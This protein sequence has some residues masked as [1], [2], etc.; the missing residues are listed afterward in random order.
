MRGALVAILTFF[1]FWS[2][3]API[4][5]GDVRFEGNKSYSGAQL[6]AILRNRYFVSLD[7]DFGATDVNDA[8]FY[9]RTFYLTRGY[10]NADVAS[11]YRPTRPP[12]ALFVINEGD[13]AQIG[14]VT[15][16]GESVLG[17]DE[18][19]AV[20]NAAVRQATLM[21][22]G[23]MRYVESAVE[24][25]RLAVVNAMVLRGCLLANATV[26]TS[27]GSRDNFVNVT[28]HL[29]PGVQ[30][31]VRD[32]TFSG[33]PQDAATLRGVLAD[34]IN[35]PFQRNQ[36]TLMRN[37]LLDWLRNHGYLQAEVRSDFSL[38]AAT[39][40]VVG[41]FSIDAGRVYTI[42]RIRVEGLK[43]TRERAVR[44][45]VAL[46][47]GTTYDASR[48]DEAARRLWF[49]GAF[50]EADIEREPQPDGT[51]DL[52][53]KVAESPA[54]RIQFGL[55]YSQWEQVYGEIHYVDRNLFGT[56][57]RFTIDAGIS[58][59]TY[60]IAAGLADPWIFG[61]DLEGSAQVSLTRRELPAYRA[62]QAAAT[63]SLTRRFNADT[64]TGY[65]FQYGY[66]LVTDAVVFGDDSDVPD[67]NY[68]VGSIAFGQTWDTRNN[69]LSPMKG[70]YLNY[71][72]QLANPA[73]LGSLSFARV[74]GQ[75]TYYQPLRPITTER[76]FV[77]F[78]IF[79][80]R[81][82]VIVPYGNTSN[83][84]V[85]ERFFLGGPNT[86]RSF[87]LDGLGPRDSDGDPLGGLA[88]LLFNAEIQWPVINNFYLAAFADAGN[89][90]SDA[91]LI[92]PMDLRVG[93]GPGVRVYT[94]LGAIRVDY[95][96]NLNRQAGDPIGAWQIGFG[97]TF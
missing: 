7:G 22:F 42:G 21:P 27:A 43:S 91:N 17:R 1:G 11:T 33:A 83:I 52:V 19:N 32:V 76:P 81:A 15:F 78:L 59:K 57:N 13:R 97:F 61:T 4:P 8:A 20:F 23:R 40:R 26:S 49:S 67:P 18:L 2:K 56:L 35:Q 37:R 72:V 93:V 36:E 3:P 68:T 77:P 55:G 53:V 73:L 46:Q 94:P 31:F 70:L 25:G 95:G 96:Y 71:N 54:K 45:R 60:G 29:E 5:A 10:R 75:A 85:Q 39:G 87:Q 63:L 82:G 50:S 64:L 16:V 51:V 44:K 89:L 6:L 38:D 74:S 24:A 48:V 9:L 86:V 66:S 12:G 14:V 90:W 41:A 62:V 80:H 65:Q 69:I 47:P 84:P 79:N 30:Y 88:F 92:Q 58:Q 34:F 28:I